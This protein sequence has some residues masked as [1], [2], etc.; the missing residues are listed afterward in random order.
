MT[1][2][3]ECIQHAYQ[4]VRDHSAIEQK[5]QKANYDW[6]TW[7]NTFET[8]SKLA[9]TDSPGRIHLRMAA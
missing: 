1:D 2:L 7:E 6:F 8:E 5:K 9:M 3:K 4:R